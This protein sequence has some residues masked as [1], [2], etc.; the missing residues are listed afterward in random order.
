MLAGNAEGQDAIPRD[1]L[2]TSTVADAKTPATVTLDLGKNDLSPQARLELSVT[3]VKVSPKEGYVMVVTPAGDANKQLGSF[4]F[5]PPP[6]EGEVRKFYVNVPR[7]ANVRFDAKGQVE[8]SI[9]LVPVDKDKNLLDSSVRVV[10]AR[11]VG[12]R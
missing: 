4:S 12:D 2:V 1:V 10:G 3:P 7:P 5:F 8:L 11:V 9:E 6:R